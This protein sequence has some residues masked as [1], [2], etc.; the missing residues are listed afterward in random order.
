M[1]VDSL[2]KLMV[3]ELKDLYDAEK[4]ITEALPK[5]AEEAKTSDLRQ[6]FED[7]LKQTKGHVRRQLHSGQVRSPGL[8]RGRR[9]G[10]G[11]ARSRP[12]TARHPG[13]PPPWICSPSGRTVGRL[14]PRQREARSR[15]APAGAG[16]WREVW[17]QKRAGSGSRA[18]ET[19]AT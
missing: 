17:R 11:G 12:G 5:M 10:R 19:A 7:H 13:I 14:K 4:Q 9:P 8:L 6:A 2:E 16:L 15:P 3:E 1:K 18:V